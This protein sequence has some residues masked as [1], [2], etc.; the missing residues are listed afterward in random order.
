MNF[1]TLADLNVDKGEF[2]TYKNRLTSQCKMRKF[3][4]KDMGRYVKA[5]KTF[6]PPV[7]VYVRKIGTQNGMDIWIV[8]GDKIRSFIDIDF[9]TG[10]H[11]VRYLYVPM[12]EIWV[13]STLDKGEEIEPTILHETVEFNLMKKGINYYEAHTAASIIESI[14]REKRNKAKLN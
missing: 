13:D 7:D 4:I 11:G 9:T 14:D 6:S 1:E 5:K 8:D 2:E 10:G 12:N 3:C